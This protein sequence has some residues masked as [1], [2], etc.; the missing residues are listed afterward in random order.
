[1]SRPLMSIVPAGE[2]CKVPASARVAAP[3]GTA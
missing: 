1:M 3:E 2:S